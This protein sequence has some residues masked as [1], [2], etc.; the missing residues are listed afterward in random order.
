[1]KDRVIAFSGSREWPLEYEWMVE[2]AIQA[3]KRISVS[4][5]Q[6]LVLVHGAARGVDT[7]VENLSHIYLARTLVFPVRSEDW[8]RDGKRAG[9]LR[10]EKMIQSTNPL[11]VYGFCLNG[12]K[13]TT[14]AVSVAKGLGIETVV[15]NIWNYEEEAGVY[16]A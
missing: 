1:M 11:K 7:F 10:N 8:E 12:S 13:G 3:E 5:G 14:H 6:D 4:K 9:I 15:T 2:H 16:L